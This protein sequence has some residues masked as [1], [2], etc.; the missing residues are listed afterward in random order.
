MRTDLRRWSA[1]ERG[2]YCMEAAAKGANFIFIG[3][4]ERSAG[5]RVQAVLES[6]NWQKLAETGGSSF[7][8]I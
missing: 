3:T 8:P 5:T 2:Y 7:W 1:G 6:R 4:K